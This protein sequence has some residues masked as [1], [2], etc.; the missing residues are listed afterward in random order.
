MTRAW[1]DA[2][3]NYTPDCDLNNGSAQDLRTGGGDFCG[4]LSNQNF[5]KNVYSLSYD[6]QILKGWGVTAIRLDHQRRPSSTSCCRGSRSR[7]ATRGAGSQN[8]TVTD[9]RATTAADYTPFSITAPL[10]PRLP[11]GG[12][13]VVS[14]LYDV[15]PAQFN[16]VDNYRTYAPDYG[17]ISQMYN[18]IEFNVAAR[19]RNGFQFQAGS[20]TG[21]RVT[22]YCEVRATELARSRPV[23]YF[24]PAASCRTTV[25]RTPTATT[26]RG[27]TRDS[28][29]SAPTRFPKIDVLFSGALTSS[30]GIPLRAD[31]TVSNAIVAQ[32]LGRPLAGNVANVDREP[33]EAGRHAERSGQPARLPR[34]EDPAARP[35]AGEHRAR[36]VQR[37]E[38]GHDHLSEPG[39]RPGR[40]VAGADRQGQTR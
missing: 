16:A 28:P 22:D 14:G 30:A 15:V 3:G 23:P 39:V 33:A 10:D 8:F 40:G 32:S 31:W 36:P 29:A 37:V 25:R 21:Q 26:R 38:P 12:G 7:S 1:T 27:S 2:N 11:G 34:R 24:R 6:E 9:N 5:G 4:A 18:G 13:Y 35:D 19:L 20:V 17:T